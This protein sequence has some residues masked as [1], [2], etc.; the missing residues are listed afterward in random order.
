MKGH[1][2]RLGVKVRRSELRASIHR[3]DHERT[4]ERHSHV[5][6]RR[7]Y[8]VAAPNSVWHVDGNHKLIRWRLVVHAGV[9]GFSRSIVY[10]ECASNNKSATVLNVFRVG[11]SEFGDESC[12][13][14]GS[15]IYNERVERMWRDVY[16]CVSKHYAEFGIPDCVRSGDGG[17]NVGI[18]S[19]MLNIHSGDESCVIAG[20]SIYNERVERM[21][22]DVYRCVSKQYADLFQ[23]LERDGF[24]DPLNED[25]IFALY[26]LATH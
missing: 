14:A 17:E 20:S 15:S 11:V 21:W 6:N 1:L 13:I 16:R 12:V 19:Y 26:I 2:M 9:D 10:I 25:D 7:T 3:V 24:L 8:L 18:W 5:V 22:R 23:S 4:V